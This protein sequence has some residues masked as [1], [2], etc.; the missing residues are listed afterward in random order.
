MAESSFKF[1]IQ[2]LDELSK[3]FTS[4]PVIVEPIIQ[5]AINKSK[6]AIDAQRTPQNIP[7]ITGNLANRWT[8]LFSSLMLKT[9]P[10]M[11]YARAVQYGKEKA[12]MTT[13]HRTSAFGR[14][15]KPYSFTMK[16][17][18]FEGRHYMEKILAAAQP[19]IQTIFSNALKETVSAIAK[20]SRP[21]GF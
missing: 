15:T 18:T 5:E 9:K 21:K 16:W 11:K 19:D 12:E 2:G 1:D 6:A 14:P 13:F 4:S 8:T 7:W 3:S 20:N 10:D 17:P